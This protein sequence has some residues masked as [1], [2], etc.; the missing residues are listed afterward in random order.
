MAEAPG[1]DLELDYS[2]E[3]FARSNLAAAMKKG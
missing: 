1:F 2:P 3:R